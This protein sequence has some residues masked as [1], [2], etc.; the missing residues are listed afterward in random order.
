MLSMFY[1]LTHPNP[2]LKKEGLLNLNLTQNAKL[3]VAPLF[4][5]WNIPIFRG[6]GL[7]VSSGVCRI[8]NANYSTIIF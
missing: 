4:F 8:K 7:G 1:V 6:E 3:S 2:S 5:K